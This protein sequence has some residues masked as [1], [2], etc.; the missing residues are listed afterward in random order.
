MDYTISLS[1]TEVTWQPT[2]TITAPTFE[3]LYGK[4]IARQKLFATFF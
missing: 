1:Q 4:R 2:R 3:S